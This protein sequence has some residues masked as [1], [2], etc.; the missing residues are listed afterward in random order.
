MMEKIDY[1]SICDGH[2]RLKLDQR[3]NYTS[4]AV[5]REVL[6]EKVG[7]VGS[8]WTKKAIVIDIENLM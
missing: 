3:R 8:R 1:K 2:L 5:Y 4:L 6:S 7:Q